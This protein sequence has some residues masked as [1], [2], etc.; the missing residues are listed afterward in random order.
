MWLARSLRRR[1][2][3]ADAAWLILQHSI[4]GPQMQRL[5]LS[6]LETAT[7]VGEAPMVCVAMLEDRIR[8]NEGKGQRYGTQSIGTKM[9]Y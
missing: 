2:E 9:V 4:G 5:G 6:L 7:A 3:A 8:C 1:N